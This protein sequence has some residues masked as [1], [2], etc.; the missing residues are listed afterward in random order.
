MSTMIKALTRQFDARL[1]FS[2]TTLLIVG[3]W[4]CVFAMFVAMGLRS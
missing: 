2:R 4:A 1:R 3:L